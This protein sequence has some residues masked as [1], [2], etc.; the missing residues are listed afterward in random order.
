MKKYTRT[1][2]LG[3]LAASALFLS[4]CATPAPENSSA[5]PAAPG[6]NESGEPG[7]SSPPSQ[8]PG[9][10]QTDVPEQLTF[11]ASLL[12]SGE[13]FDAST[14]AGTDAILWFWAPWCPSCQAEAPLLVDALSQLPEGVTV[15]GV[16]GQSDTDS[17]QAFVDEYGVDGIEHIVDADGTIWANFLVATQPAWVLIDDDGSIRTIPGSLGTSGVVAAAQELVSN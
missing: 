3:A 5:A 8:S 11:T 1:A 14:L 7:V 4:A 9:G 13:E 10:A 6:A 12:G 16:P 15:Y 2:A 17:M